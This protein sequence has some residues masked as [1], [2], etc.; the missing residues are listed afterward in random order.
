MRCVSHGERC[1]F[2]LTADHRALVKEHSRGTLFDETAPYD[3]QAWI[4]PYLVHPI[5]IAAG[6]PDR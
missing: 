6:T 1:D 4:E 5:A 2:V 3:S